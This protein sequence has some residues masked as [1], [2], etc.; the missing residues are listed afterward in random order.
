MESYALFVVLGVAIGLVLVPPASDVAT[1]PDGTVAVVAIDGTIDGQQATDYAEA[2]ET[3]REEADAVV[4]VA[5]SGGG[6]AAAS[7]EMYM[8]TVRTAAEMPVIAAVDGGALSGA[9]YA[10]VPAERIYV[11]PASSVGSVGVVADTPPTIEPNDL[12]T[13]TG[14]DK[15]A[16]SDE[17]QFVHDLAT[18]QNAFL[19]AVYE[20]RGDRLELTEEELGSAATYTGVNAVERGVVDDVA[21]RQTALEM[22]ASE[23]DLDRPEVRHLRT[24]DEATFLLQ[25]TY[26]ASETSDRERLDPQVL[27]A[28]DD[29][30]PPA[31]LMVPATTLD[32]DGV[33]SGADAMHADEAL[34]SA[35]DDA[36]AR[37]DAERDETDSDAGS[38]PVPRVGG[39]P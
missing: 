29:P 10:I 17:R 5:N 15:L 20:H 11:K 13:T 37:D 32:D 8:Q 4:I 12:I 21:D 14:P 18:L 6:S 25:S 24:D 38:T 7:E 19:G 28:S 23:A 36:E 33:V 2:M 34:R 16:G 39:A 9:Y 1:A 35:D 26:L 27:Q 22:A 31:F 30:G 3:A